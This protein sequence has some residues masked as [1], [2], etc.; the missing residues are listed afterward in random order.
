[1]GDHRRLHVPVTEELLHGAD[2][3]AARQEMAGEAVSQGVAARRLRDP[4]AADRPLD[5][6]LHR[7]LVEVVA[8]LTPGRAIQVAPARREYP[9]PGPLAARI[10]VLASERIRE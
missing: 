2:V 4:R 10:R 5:R 1:M 9:L 6:A 7:C 8:P 3:V